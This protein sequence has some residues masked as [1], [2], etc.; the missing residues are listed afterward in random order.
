M[1]HPL[2]VTDLNTNQHVSHEMFKKKKNSWSQNQTNRFPA[3]DVAQVDHHVHV[4]SPGVKLPLPGGQRGQRHHH[5]KGS[6]ELMLV[7]QV[8]QEGDGLDG[9]PQPHLIGQDDAVA[10]ASGERIL[11]WDQNLVLNIKPSTLLVIY[12]HQE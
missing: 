5:Q 12:L 1:V 11:Y 7:E 10:P 8:G 2:V 4:R 6:V 3:H 9:L